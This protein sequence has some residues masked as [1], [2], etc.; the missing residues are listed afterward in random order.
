V[1]AAQPLGAFALPAGF[2][3]VPEIDDPS[4][5]EAVASLLAGR[6]PPSWPAA[7]RAHE[8]AH[9]GDL[10]AAHAVLV[11]DDPYTL[12]NRYVLAPGSLDPRTVAAR[13][14]DELAPLVDVVRYT[15]GGC[16]EPPQLGSDTVACAIVAGL[17]LAVQATHALADGR[18]ADAVALLREAAELVVGDSPPLAALLRG[19]AGT[20]GYEHGLDRDAARADLT[21]AAAALVDTD[22]DVNKAELHYQLGALEHEQAVATG[23]SL[24]SAMHHYYTTLQLVTERTAPYLWASAQLNLATAYLASP[25]VQAS[26]SLRTGIAIQ[27]MRAALGIFTRDDHPVQW[28]TTTLNLANALIYSPSMKQGDNLVEAVELYEE[29]LA[30]RDRDSDP[31]GRAR[32]LANQG[33]ALAHLGIFD[34]AKAKLYEARFLFEELLD[35]DSALAVRSVL[36]EIAKQ[37]VPATDRPANGRL[38]LGGVDG[39]VARAS[40][41]DRQEAG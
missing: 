18:A 36:D 5:D 15:T 17:V 14:P 39:S 38:A 11:G 40:Q 30:L 8:F 3:L 24:R 37:L 20:I 1:S 32:V 34:Q 6:L 33:N 28:A 4:V 23:A 29:V 25:M 31:L 10:V 16:D 22:L 9:A 26:D 19:N 13:L 35:H 2:M 21:A 12:Y 27:A 7:M 41:G